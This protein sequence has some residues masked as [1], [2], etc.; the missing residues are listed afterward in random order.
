MNDDPKTW[1]AL[2]TAGLALLGTMLG[3]VFQLWREHQYFRLDKDRVRAEFMAEEVAKKLLMN[4][5]APYR[6]FRILR[7]HLGGFTDDELRRILVRTGAIRVKSKS[8]DELWI[9]VDRMVEKIPTDGSFYWR[10]D[11]DP[12]T[13]P[14]EKLFP[15]ALPRGDSNK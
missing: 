8:G 12:A 1:V 4:K 11:K 5:A 6:T 3:L 15:A 10:I 14:E 9:L 7:H 13:P 2:I